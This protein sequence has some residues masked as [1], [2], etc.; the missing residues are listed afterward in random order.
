MTKLTWP[1]WF[2]SPDGKSKAIF[3]HESDVPRGWTS[4]A[5]K[6]TVTA[7]KEPAIPA[8]TPGTSGTEN[9]E[10]DADGWPWSADLHASTK[11]K[12]KAGLW[13]M[14]VGASRPAPKEGFPKSTPAET[15]APPPLDL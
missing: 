13:R 5:E 14:K 3:E 8:P 9:V 15:G 10:V 12:T 6:I 7:L 2:N 1:A 4:G 11:A